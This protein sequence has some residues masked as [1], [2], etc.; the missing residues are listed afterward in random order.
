MVTI[1]VRN[2]V[3]VGSACLN[4]VISIIFNNNRKIE[5]QTR[6]WF[7]IK[8]CQDPNLLAEGSDQ[9]KFDENC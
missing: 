3:G 7:L 1:V 4:S 8:T 6:K 5:E 2:I 9:L